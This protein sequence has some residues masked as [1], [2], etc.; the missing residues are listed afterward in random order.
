MFSLLMLFM[1]SIPVNAGVADIQYQYQKVI[2]N[3]QG[4]D[5][6]IPQGYQ[7]ELLTD[8]LD[9]PRIMTFVNNGDLLIGSR[10]GRIYRLS[11]P[12]HTPQI[13]LELDDYPHSVVVRNNSMY[14]AQ[15]DGLY[16]VPYKHGQKQVSAS[17]VKRLLSLPGGGGHNSRTV[18]LGPDGRI[19]LSL[20]I[21]GNCSDQ[22]LGQGYSFNERRGGI[23]VLNDAE[24]PFWEIYASGLRNPV[25]FDWHPQTGVMYASNNG[26]DHS[27]F[28]QPPEYFSRIIK[29][30]FHGMPWYQFDGLKLVRDSCI[31]SQPPL[32]VSKVTVPVVT[33][34]AR[35]APMGVAFVNNPVF[36]ATLLYDA[37]VAL[38]GSWG[39]RPNGGFFGAKSTRRP[40]KIVIVRFENGKAIRVDDL[41][42]GF[43][44][45]NGSR[46]ARPIGVTI[47]PDGALYFTSDGGVHGLYRLKRVVVD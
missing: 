39:T 9:N 3:R 13:L 26:P 38:H 27:G 18:R 2:V 34:P 11:P 23:L 41:I 30:S 15:T 47:G 19:Y 31:D 6:R 46:W 8:Q 29:G 28:R 12:Y 37:I 42:T 25:G 32:P 4:F 36:G 45:N 16:I 40:P 10:S 22:F 21:S 14:I 7:L 24:K 44:L 20:G 17:A 43:Q 33:F 1:T 5:V 35:N